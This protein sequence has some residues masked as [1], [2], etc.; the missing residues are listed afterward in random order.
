VLYVP[1]EKRAVAFFDGQ[2]LFY[3]AKHAFGYTF[4]NYDVAALADKVASVNGWRLVETRFYTGIPD[5]V[6]D[7]SRHGF[8]ASKTA[9]MR[10][11][12]IHAFTRPLRPRTVATTGP[13]GSVAPH[14]AWVEKG[15]DVRIAI[16]IISLAFRKVFDVAIVFSQDQDLSEVANEIR[17]IAAAQERWIK[18]VSAYPVGAG[19]SNARGI[20]STDWFRFDKAFYDTCIDPVDY[21]PKR[22]PIVP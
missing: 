11:Q 21:R 12:G 6:A 1:H 2:N 17:Q 13:A 5:V 3:G 8:W 15:I 14:T 16:D 4:P 20:N 9:A 22:P 7:P 19:Y 18:I 10:R